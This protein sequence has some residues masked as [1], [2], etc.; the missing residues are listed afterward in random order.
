MM[1]NKTLKS[2]IVGATAMGLLTLSPLSF[3]ND[4]SFVKEAAQGNLMEVQ[5]GKMGQ[6]KAASQEV[7][8]F[9]QRMVA[10]HGKANDQ[11]KPIAKKLKVNW[12]ND[13]N[14]EGKQMHA[15]LEKLQG[16]EFDR[17]YVDEM[18][19]DHKKDVEKYEKAQVNVKDKDLRE[20]V[21]KTL[22]ILH[23]HLKM[24]KGL[25][26]NMSGQ[27]TGSGSAASGSAGSGSSVP[28]SSM[29]LGTPPADVATTPEQGASG[30]GSAGGMGSGSSDASGA[31]SSGLTT[32][33]ETGKKA[34]YD[35]ME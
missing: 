5:M 8:D 30:S 16:P 35:K 13:L 9:G 25:K 28:S 27:G 29:G 23:E 3:A 14:A 33:P 31:G 34:K 2:A 18:V 11:L 22:P 21:N 26:A 32:P 10:D 17:K 19:K 7:K 15:E 20:Y 4:T 12:P 6:E 24:A 1:H